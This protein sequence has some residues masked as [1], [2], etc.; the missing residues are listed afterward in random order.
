M[1]PEDTSPGG[2]E[3]RPEFT[4]PLTPAEKKLANQASAALRHFK[5][6]DLTGVS[7]I[8]KQ[9]AEVA[10]ISVLPPG[11]IESINRSFM[12][13]FS[14]G[15]VDTSAFKL[16]SPNLLKGFDF[17]GVTA[18]AE[19]V[20]KANFGWNSQFQ[21]IASQLA[22]QHSAWLKNL[23]KLDFKLPYPANLDSIED[24][25][26][27]EIEQVILV[28]GIPLYGVPRTAIAKALIRAE[29]PGKR[30][31]ILG[32][33]KAIS[34]DCRAEVSGCTTDQIEPLKRFAL[35]A[36]DALDAGHNEAAQ[37]LAANPLDTM[38]T[39]MPRAA[40]KIGAREEGHDQRALPRAGSQGV[41]GVRTDRER[42]S[43]LPAGQPGPNPE[44]VQ[45]SRH[46]SWRQHEPVLEG[47]RDPG[48]D[49]GVQHPSVRGRPLRPEHVA[50]SSLLLPTFRRD[51]A[52]EPFRGQDQPTSAVGRIG[53]SAGRP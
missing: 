22:K 34:T 15:L 45:P 17:G 47:Q 49:A 28:E 18:A 36:L 16:A 24:L 30:R 6:V 14:A 12:P 53:V 23:T 43:E 42:P 52:G 26:L 25:K 39:Y 4:R 2:E 48:A 51:S 3:A 41:A 46:C 5:G 21:D 11:F 7:Q 33:R 32:R 40:E 35:L 31:E 27:E 44:D 9:F 13:R 10:K 29:S 19:L 20:A 37:A 1:S 38:P 50:A 8:Q